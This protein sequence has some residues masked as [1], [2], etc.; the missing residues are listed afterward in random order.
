MSHLQ[1][2]SLILTDTFYWEKSR[3]CLQEKL[4]V[5]KRRLQNLNFKKMYLTPVALSFPKVLLDDITVTLLKL[6]IILFW[7]VNVPDI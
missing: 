2:G 3:R 6:E 5:G 4:V 7:Q 1:V